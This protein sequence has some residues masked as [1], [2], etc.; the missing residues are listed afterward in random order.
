L[1]IILY[2][3]GEEAD[4]EIIVKRSIDDEHCIDHHKDVEF[5][6]VILKNGEDYT[7][8]SG[9]TIIKIK[10]SV[11]KNLRPGV[12]TLKVIF[13][14]GLSTTSLTVKEKATESNTETPTE[15]PT[16]ATTEAATVTTEAT[17]QK[18]T[19]KTTEKKIDNNASTGDETDIALLILLIGL[20]LSAVTVIRRKKTK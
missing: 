17:T 20:S 16:E 9:S 15:A 18:T 7:A 11:I 8:E 4:Q 1:R 13:D 3:E 6:G 10:G 5:G 2:P 12:Y 14:D 19:E